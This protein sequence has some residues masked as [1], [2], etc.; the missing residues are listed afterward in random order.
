MDIRPWIDKNP[1]ELILVC[2]SR[3]DA[4]C[5]RIWTACHRHWT[6]ILLISVVVALQL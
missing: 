1:G 2:V 6:R 5:T 3:S 4:H